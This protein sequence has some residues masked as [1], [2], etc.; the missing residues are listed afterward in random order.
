MQKSTKKVAAT[1]RFLANGCH[2]ILAF[3]ILLT[4]SSPFNQ[5]IPGGGLCVFGY[6][7]CLSSTKWQLE[8]IKTGLGQA[9]TYLTIEI[10]ISCC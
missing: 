6:A 3:C 9:F 7:T 5:L 4:I 2:H 8:Y 10:N 1:I